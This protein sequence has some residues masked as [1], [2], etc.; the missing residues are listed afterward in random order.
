MTVGLDRL[1]NLGGLVSTPLR[2]AVVAI[3]IQGIPSVQWWKAKRGSSFHDKKIADFADERGVLWLEGDDF[4]LEE[5]GQTSRFCKQ[6]LFFDV[7]FCFVR[8][9][10]IY[11][12][13]F[14]CIRMGASLGILAHV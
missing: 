12:Y 2:L 14:I 10:C 11:I 7:T 9:Y 6:F 4:E 3:L 8:N 1:T 13:V 5:V